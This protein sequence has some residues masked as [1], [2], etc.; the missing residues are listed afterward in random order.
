MLSFVSLA[1]QIFQDSLQYIFKERTL[2]W[3]VLLRSLLSF[4]DF[5]VE[6]CSLSSISSRSWPLRLRSG[7]IRRRYGLVCF[8]NRLV[9]IVEWS[10]FDQKRPG[11]QTCLFWIYSLYRLIK[12]KYCWQ[13]LKNQIEFLLLWFLEK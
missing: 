3:E 2:F 7:L 10:C 12:L 4:L 9:W 5:R 1:N 8:G 6:C 11:L 13:K